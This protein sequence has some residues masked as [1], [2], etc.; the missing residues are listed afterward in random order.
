MSLIKRQHLPL[1]CAEHDYKYD[2]LTR[3]EAGG[4]RQEFQGKAF[5]VNAAARAG[6]PPEASE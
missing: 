4:E 5:T 2:I 1:R 3:A 6:T